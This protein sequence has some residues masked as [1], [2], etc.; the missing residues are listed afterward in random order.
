MAKH[1][2]PW[3]YPAKIA[4]DRFSRN[5]R[6]PNPASWGRIASAFNAVSMYRRRMV[7]A[8]GVR[9]TAVASVTPGALVQNHYFLFRTQKNLSGIAAQ[10][11]V[12]PASS[13]L[14]EDAR[15]RL[16]AVPVADTPGGGTTV[17]GGYVRNSLVGVSSFA[18]S[19]VAWGGSVIEGLDEDTLYL[20]FVELT[21][22]SS[23]SSLCVYQEAPALADDSLD[24]ICDPT[25][26]ETYGEIDAAYVQ[27]VVQAGIELH[28]TAGAQLISWSVPDSFGAPSLTSTAYVNVIDN[29]ST[30]NDDTSPG[31]QIS[32]QYH[33]RAVNFIGIEMAA[34]VRRTA[35]TGTVQLALM[36]PD[37]TI[38]DSLNPIDGTDVAV[39]TGTWAANSGPTKY[40][41]V[42]R[43]SD[44]STT[45]EID[46][47]A[48][49]EYEA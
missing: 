8:W 28:K 44:G 5:G 38:L 3:I 46:A 6:Y 9:D 27:K 24:T 39:E 33:D 37:G 2:V 42:G 32:T 48:A 47:F 18:P 12:P 1:T 22:A 14:S 15:V 16:A 23:V 20:G 4:A 31:F 49:W 7:T 36:R 41:L 10:V 40:D 29:T 25:A 34:K 21:D 26:A 13:A 43:V 19:Q 17:Y 45:Y 35:G 11:G 30:A